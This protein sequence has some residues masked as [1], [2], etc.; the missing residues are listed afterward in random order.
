MSEP[1]FGS[2]AVL[3]TEIIAQDQTITPE[4]A[5]EIAIGKLTKSESTRNKGCPRATF[6][7]L[8]QQGLVRGIPI[9]DYTKG[10]RN[11]QYAIEAIKIIREN[12]EMT[13]NKTTLWKVVSNGERSHNGQLDVVL[14]LYKKNLLVIR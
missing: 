10:S 5:W 2:A 13:S 11:G 1:V 12:P 8:C 14:G 6:L 9:G 4:H 3:A 7:F